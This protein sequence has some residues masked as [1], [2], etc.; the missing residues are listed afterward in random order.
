MADGNETAPE[1]RQGEIVIIGAGIVGACCAAYLALEGRRVVVVDAEEP[2]CGASYG[3]AG[4]LSPGSCL[5]L[6]MPGILRKVP[7][8]LLRRDGPLVVRPGYA[9]KALPWLARFVAA[10]RISRVESIADALRALHAPTHDC[11]RPLI[12]AAGASSLVR[13]TGSLVVYRTA[14]SFSSGSFDRKMRRERGARFE[15]LDAPDIAELVPALGSQFAKAI[16]QSDHGF[17]ANPK[18]LTVKLLGVAL[19]RGGRLIRGRATAIAEDGEG[20]RIRLASGE[21]VSGR[22]VVIATGAWSGKLLKPLAIRVPLESQRGYHLHLSDPG[23]ELPLPVSFSE[24]KFYATPMSNG[25]RL[26]GTVEFAGLDAAPDYRRARQVGAMAERWFPGLNLQAS[27]HWMGHRPCLPDSLPVIGLAPGRH[28]IWLAFGHGHNGMTGAPATGRLIAELVAGR[29]PF[30]DP[31][32]YR[33][34]R[35]S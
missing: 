34:E 32:P 33:A 7:S 22:H 25:L 35:F 1:D 8:W 2:G 20:V 16:L 24:A 13:R 30:I 17:V 26:A 28:R 4:A 6:S 27:T 14:E 31:T 23:I 21:P 9:L 12:E 29:T 5:P 18:A 11:Y 10:G 15:V 3:N 19:A